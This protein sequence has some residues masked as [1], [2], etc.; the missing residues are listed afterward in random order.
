MGAS[1]V[2][3][4][5]F[6]NPI[7]LADST[8]GHN[9]DTY[10]G[11]DKPSNV[12]KVVVETKHF[13]QSEPDDFERSK[14][15]KHSEKDEFHCIKEPNFTL[16]NSLHIDIS[17]EILYNF[18]DLE[19]PDDESKHTAIFD[20]IIDDISYDFE[21][22][23][24]VNVNVNSSAEA[25][26]G[27]CDNSNDKN[28]LQDTSCKSQNLDDIF[29]RSTNFSPI[30]FPIDVN[31]CFDR[32]VDV[33][34]DK[35][36]DCL[37]TVPL[38]MSK[39]E[40]TI[41]GKIN[42][43]EVI[44]LV[45]TGA[46]VSAVSSS[47][48]D[49]HLSQLCLELEDSKF[50]SVNTVGNQCLPV[51]GKINLPLKIGSQ[52]YSV[53]IHVIKDLTYQAILG[54]DF[55]VSHHGNIDFQSQTLQIRPG[56][57]SLNKEQNLNKDSLSV[58]AMSNVILPPQSEMIVSAE[59][60]VS[61]T[62][63]TKFGLITPRD[64]LPYKY[65]IFGAFELVTLREDGVIPI[66]LI[67]PT[68]KPVKIYRRTKLA[69][70]KE[71]EPDIATF[72][73]KDD[74]KSLPKVSN[75]SSENNSNEYSKLPDL[76]NSD[77]DENSKRKLEQL[78]YKFRD[79]FPKDKS[80]L[81]RTNLVQH[82]IE[83]G[84]YPPIKQRP[85]RSNPEGR[86]EIDKQVEEMLENN[87]IQPSVSPWASPVVLVKKKDGTMR[88]CVDY[89][90]LNAVTYKDSFPI[91]LVIDAL[92]SMTGAQYFSTLDLMSGYWQIPLHP[93]A[94][95]KT[96]FV[97]H[98]GLYEFLVM[99][100]GLCNAP[101][102][103]QRLMSHILRGLQYKY[104]LIYIDDILVYSK[105][106]DEHI[107]HLEEIFRR[108][109][110][111][112]VKLNSNK[113]HFAKKEVL[114]LGHVITPEGIKPNPAK[115]SVVKDFP[116]PRNLK[117]LRNF[118]GLAN[119]YRRFVKDF[120]K[121]ANP[122]HE[123]TCKR[124][125]FCWTT[126]CAEAFDKLKRALVSAPVL[127]FPDF[128]KEF[129]LFVDACDTG[130]GM[131]LSQVQ[132]NK[133]V[134]VAYDGRGL[135]KSERNYSTTEKECLALISAIKKFQPYLHGRKF[136]VYTDHSS[137][138]WLLNMKNANGRLARWSLLIQQY[139]FEIIH[140][141]GK[142]N[143]NADSLSRRPYNICRISS[144][145]TD[146]TEIAEKQ[147]RDQ[148]LF[149]IIEFLENDVLP[150][151]DTKARKLLLLK[152]KFFIGEDNLLY[153]LNQTH[154]RRCRSEVIYSQL[155]VP[156]SMKYEVLSNLHDHVAGGHFGVHKTFS[157]V[158]ER[159][160][161]DGMFKDVEHWCKSCTDCSTRKTPRNRK[162]APL[163]PIPVEGAFHRIGIDVLGP[164]PESHR[165]NRYIVVVSD[166]L[167]RWPE[168][169]AVSSTEAT[170]IARLLVDEIIARHGAPKELLSDRG[171]NFLSKIV[172]EVCKIFQIHK[173]NT[174]S[175][176][177]QT[178]GV[179]ERFNSTLC[180]SL[181]MYVSKTQ[182]DW[183]EYIPL[184]L[185]AYRTSV[186]ETTGDSPFYL[187]YGREPRLPLDT[188]LLQPSDLSTSIS[189][190]RRKIVE[191]IEIAQ[192]LAK[193]NIQRTQQSMKS[194][195]DRKAKDVDF[196]VGD[197]VWVF[198]PKSKKGL[199]RKLAHNWHGPFRISRKAS[200]VLFFLKNSNNKKIDFAVHA[201]RMKH[202]VDPNVRPIVPENLDCE[203][204]EPFLSEEDI[205]EDSF[206]PEII[207]IDNET[208]FE[209]EKIL[210]LRRRKGRNEY[211]IKWKG[212]NNSSNSWEP[213]ENINEQLVEAFN[214]SSRNN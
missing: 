77:L 102:S 155:V 65:N 191:K 38:V 21:T 3:K 74:E 50:S 70:F 106:I 92:D 189:E 194:Y 157:K 54:R 36:P 35:D 130:I 105:S 116:V 89:R 5:H 135:L 48:W 109:R 156:S 162:R 86:K 188:K 207:P 158:S 51:L 66:R 45:D 46:A 56:K 73:L 213:E 123:L 167:T 9:N 16:D 2:N 150:D 134:V 133:E 127:V 185:F 210:K 170:V 42:N 192:Q 115:I 153:H 71:V 39:G 76:S 113:C 18:E 196:E 147:R 143:S 68:I 108:L 173:V 93:S 81:G 104:A 62:Q 117:E 141:P 163:L 99:P 125:K 78:L 168:A 90:K 1:N 91:P 177:P 67:N 25:K 193:E 84:T 131:T 43:F 27:I 187:L 30:E 34:G 161:W 20:E 26:I 11:V 119:Y 64:T 63:S 214:D 200:P 100:F 205:P 57:S 95:E 181:S 19:F 165:G 72:E 159:Y 23:E 97:T 148:D 169:F 136:K 88:F 120:A 59:V 14:I 209:V 7:S 199:S 178:D 129:L 17:D 110:E 124:V 132:N 206:E 32:N 85:Y 174:S 87:F 122:L 31:S 98:N 40:V 182:K 137:L 94:M 37:S 138:R 172:A 146:V 82:T 175:F 160:W 208:I 195:Y 211:L 28:W 171:Q 79:L 118:L 13:I 53:D 139:D 201:N 212:F 111:A 10:L 128:S 166:Y 180:Q 203:Q 49:S 164:F 44:F 47:F 6:D 202:F 197:R 24:F 183:D 15:Y 75:T 83:T 179:V 149:A 69:D 142:Y 145:E 61:S 4:K 101:S 114:Y 112:D 80:Q 186:S 55:L 190:H 126:S 144:K 198:S 96:A 152:D 22:M 184:I 52:F 154:K 151:D 12:N 29:K 107:S 140:R 58:H 33:I 204:Y 8:H 121:I 103:F 176:H 41:T 60:N